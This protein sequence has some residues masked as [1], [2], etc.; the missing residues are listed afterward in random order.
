MGGVTV[1]TMCVSL[2]VFVGAAAAEENWNLGT[3]PGPV[4]NYSFTEKASDIS[5][6]G[7]T[8]SADSN[9]PH[10][11]RDEPAGFGGFDLYSATRADPQPGPCDGTAVVPALVTVGTSGPE[12][13]VVRVVDQTLLD[14][15]IDICRGTSPQRI[16]IGPLLTGNRGYNQDASN[17]NVWSWHVGES[18]IELAEVTIELCD[19]I[20]S[21]VEA[22]LATWVEV[23]GFYCPWS[24][25]IVA[26]SPDA[27][28]PGDFDVDGDA[29]IDDFNLLEACLAG[30]GTPCWDL[31]AGCCA[32]DMDGDADIDCSDWDRFR[33]TWTGP[34]DPPPL[35]AC[36][37]MAIPAVSA[38]GLIVSALLLAI[39]GTL[40]FSRDRAR[41]IGAV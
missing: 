1:R 34:G 38:W 19:G 11:S 27:S 21:F 15:M 30:S 24:S 14:E 22:D 29:D 7:L 2:L 37:S 32:T 17:A 35:A 12:E 16:V 10:F 18:A 28:I 26:I 3:N 9:T 8:L 13:F 20:P 33:Q 31:G 5:A 36:A 25:Q 40:L 41:V 23:V 39:A 4:A 6:D